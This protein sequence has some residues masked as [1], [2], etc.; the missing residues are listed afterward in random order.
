VLPT[1]HNRHHPNLA[2][3]AKVLG[4]CRLR[5]LY[6]RNHVVDRPI[7]AVVEKADDLSSPRFSNCIEDISGGRRPSHAV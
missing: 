4:Y 1:L 5:D 3:Y 7:L 6:P 2:Q